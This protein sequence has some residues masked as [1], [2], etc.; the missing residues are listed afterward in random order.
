MQ[1][2]PV[3]FRE[4]A[5]L[6]AGGFTMVFTAWSF[7]GMQNWS[8]N[9]LLA[10][11]LLTFLTSVIPLPARWNGTD[12][13]HGNGTNVKRLLRFPFFW[14]TL[15]F[16]I[17]IAIQGLN[18]AWVQTHIKEGWYMR[19][20]PRSAFI[21]WLPSGAK[22]DYLPVSALR[23]FCY[24][25]GAF[26]LVW[27]L[28]VGLRRRKTTLAALWMFAVSGV[29]MGSVAILQKFMEAPKVLWLIE[30]ANP[31]FWGSFFY[32]NHGVAFL[33]L[34]MIVCAFLYFYHLN[35]SQRR[36]QHGGP[37]LLLF[38]FVTLVLL[39]IT[40]ALSRGGILFGTAFFAF[41]LLAVVARALFSG[42]LKSSI[43]L[44]LLMTLLLAGGG[45]TILRFI[46]FESIQGRFGNIQ[47]TIQNI[48]N[49]QRLLCTKITWEM[50]QAR[51]LYGW[52]AGTWRY[53]FPMYQKQYPRLFYKY[54]NK[55]T[56][57][58]EKRQYFHYAH[59]DLAQFLAEYG[60]V[61][62]SFL[63]L[64]VAYWGVLILFRSHGNRM[65]AIMLVGGAALV[66]GHAFVEFIFQSPAYW[67]AVNGMSC[68]TVKLLVL[69][70]SRLR[71]S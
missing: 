10:C 51:L 34:V 68:L 42:T 31:N 22:T 40:M 20:L 21:E 71:T 61:G 62:C 24:Y 56:K 26:A 48:D 32:R 64:A 19:E 69:N 27:G 63:V 59:N 2:P 65:A 28:W 47:E 54:F 30:S 35:A 3:A 44:T 17:Y 29:L 70:Q 9:T 23:V 18:V 49:D 36:M 60:I 50:S 52:G 43:F 4:W 5:V 8:L 6:S 55:R 1:S 45:Y 66:F 16:L 12:G 14:L 46:D 15:C 41:F 53:I 11:G 25:L 58:W 38:I 37:Y 57:N 7:A 33:I 13:Q 39:S 67:V